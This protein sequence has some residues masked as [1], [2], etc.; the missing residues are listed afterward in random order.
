MGLVGE[1]S[2]KNYRYALQL[3]SLT[4]YSCYKILANMVNLFSKGFDITSIP[5]ISKAEMPMVLL[6]WIHSVSSTKPFQM[7][8]TV[9]ISQIAI[10]WR[11]MYFK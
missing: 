6:S 11:I 8:I 2:I 1:N 5:I 10:V 7:Q 9:S 3:F 4:C